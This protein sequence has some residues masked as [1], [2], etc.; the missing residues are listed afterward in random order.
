MCP[1]N[2]RAR[3]FQATVSGAPNQISGSTRFTQPTITLEMVQQMI[4][5]TFSMIGL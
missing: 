4:F 5:T 3:A 1:E 2:R